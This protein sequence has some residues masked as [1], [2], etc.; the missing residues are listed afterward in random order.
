MLSDDSKS[1]NYPFDL[2]FVT[3]TAFLY[4]WIVFVAQKNPFISNED[5]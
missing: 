1:K 3:E 4:H 5:I 2:K